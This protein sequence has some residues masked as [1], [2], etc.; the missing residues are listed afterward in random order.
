[1]RI[2]D[3]RHTNEASERVG[4]HFDHHAFAVGLD[5]AL[6]GSQLDS[7]LFVQQTPSTTVS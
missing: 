1:M 7:H 6:R 3:S 5:R 2:E 4:F